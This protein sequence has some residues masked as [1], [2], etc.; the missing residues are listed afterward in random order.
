MAR[1][2][3]RFAVRGEIGFRAVQC[4]DAG[5]DCGDSAVGRHFSCG[6]DVADGRLLWLRLY[7]GYRTRICHGTDVERG[8]C[9][10]ADNRPTPAMVLVC[11]RHAVG[12]RNFHEL[13]GGV[14]G[15]CRI[16]SHCRGEGRSG[17]AISTS[18]WGL[19]RRCVPRNDSGF[20]RSGCQA[21]CGSSWRSGKTELAN[22]RRLKWSPRW[23][24]SC[25]IQ[26]PTCSVDCRSISMV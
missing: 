1:A 25:S 12:C 21:T 9:R 22:S 26:R 11:G 10:C 20:C 18:G 4:R 6:G 7:R 23:Q 24:G 13:S 3:G 17:A 8:R 16:A 14:R 5:A 19:P 2:D 15:L